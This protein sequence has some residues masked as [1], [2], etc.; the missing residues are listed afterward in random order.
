MRDEISMALESRALSHLFFQ[1]VFGSEP[2]EE[3]LNDLCADAIIEAF[4]VFDEGDT[5]AYALSLQAV[6]EALSTLEEDLS[7]T[8]R[9]LKGEYT[10]LF[11]GPENMEAPP[12]E[13]IYTANH[14]S[15][16]QENTLAV[17]NT[18]R[19]QGFLPAEYPRVA[20][21]HI[22]LEF[23]FMAQLAERAKAAYGDGAAAEAIE[24]LSAS[25]QFLKNHLLLWISEYATRLSADKGSDFY[26]IMARMAAEFLLIDSTVLEEL[27]AEIRH[28]G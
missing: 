2:T 18:Y 10:R 9:M 4:E 17:R 21:D 14:R 25:Q 11:M 1:S 28:E 19:A 26:P 3:L 15:L 27:L 13:S 7:E 23:A 20:D 5:S 24:A 6:V 22:A 12:W 16:F 8:T